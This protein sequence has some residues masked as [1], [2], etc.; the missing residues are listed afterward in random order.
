M[1]VTK[2]ALAPVVGSGEN[3][4]LLER[5]RKMPNS[6]GLALTP[7]AM[8]D[9]PSGAQWIERPTL[10]FG[11]GDAARRHAVLGDLAEAQVAVLAVSRAIAIRFTSA[12]GA[13][14]GIGELSSPGRQRERRRV[15]LL[16]VLE[17]HPAAQM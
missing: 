6:P 3:A 11:L 12:V 17:E 2:L 16:H 7:K 5:Q 15:R 10:N 1:S 8:I 9:L 14:A 4:F 13:H